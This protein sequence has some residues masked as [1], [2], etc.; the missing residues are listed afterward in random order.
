MAVLETARGLVPYRQHLSRTVKFVLFGVEES[1]LVGSWAYVH[2]HS[3]E[4]ANTILM[5]NN[6]VGGRP[7]GII[8]IR[9]RM[10]ITHQ[11]NLAQPKKLHLEVINNRD[12]IEYLKLGRTTWDRV[13][14]EE[15]KLA[16][17]DNNMPVTEEIKTALGWMH[18]AG[19]NSDNQRIPDAQMLAGRIR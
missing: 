18:R 8:G 15:M 19:R 3:D 6:N 17:I 4:L 5:I 2:Q 1:G 10:Y 14:K 11:M 9:L 16:G 12:W 13:W 7:S